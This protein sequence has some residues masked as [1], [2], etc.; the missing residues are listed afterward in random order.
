MF[1]NSGIPLYVQLKNKLLRDIK[2]HY[3]PG[4]LLPPESALIRTYN[5]SRI[6]VRKAIEELAREDVVVKKQGKGTFVKERKVVFNANFI[7]SLTQRLAQQKRRLETRSITYT[8]LTK[9][10]PVLETLRCN[11]VLRIERVRVLE[12]IPFAIMTNYI[13]EDLVPN[14]EETFTTQSLYAF[15]KKEYGI[16]LHHAVE[17]IEAKG[18]DEREATLLEVEKGFPLL[19]LHKLSYDANNTPVE[20]SD[21][22]LRSDMYTHQIKLSMEEKGTLRQ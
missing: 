14:L 11:N 4:D 2:Q 6:T 21:V 7:G 5:V 19:S 13:V 22:V 10:H 12:G 15:I 20:F 9:G 1:E 3:A 8:T 18:A 16:Q 17:T